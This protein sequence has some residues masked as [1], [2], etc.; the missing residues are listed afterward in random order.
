MLIDPVALSTRE[1]R[2]LRAEHD[3]ATAVG[4]LVELKP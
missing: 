4:R 2:Y 1:I 3:A